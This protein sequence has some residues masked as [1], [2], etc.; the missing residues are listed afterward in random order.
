MR[1]YTRH[2]RR[3]VNTSIPAANR[4]AQHCCQLQ[5]ALPVSPCTSGIATSVAAR[6][7]TSSSTST[8]RHST[9]HGVRPTTQPLQVVA[10]LSGRVSRVQQRSFIRTMDTPNPNSLKFIPGREVLPDDGPEN[11]EFTNYKDAQKSPLGTKIFAIDGVASVFISREFVSVNINDGSDWLVVKPEV[12]AAIE[13]FYAS[14]KPVLP[15]HPIQE[16]TLIDDEDD[17][18]VAMIKELIDTRI[19]PAIQSDGGD[20]LYR[21]FENGVVRLQLQ[22][23]CVGCPSSS[24]TLKSGIENM[25]MHY[26][27]EV[28]SVEEF[29]DEVLE[30]VSSEA[31]R[32]LEE[33]LAKVQK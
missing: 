23:S 25:L 2:V 19:R 30:E 8:I 20:V 18:V 3:A 32:K 16:D 29:T 12:F 31:L 15:D 24:L 27:P 4:A 6:A 26:I 13:D 7:Y 1:A 17:E 5:R 22:G 33:G 10:R 11:I 9:S 14:G 28:E 21:G